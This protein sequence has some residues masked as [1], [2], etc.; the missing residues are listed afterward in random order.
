[1]DN[2]DETPSFGVIPLDYVKED[3]EKNE[4]VYKE[5]YVYP[6]IANG[7]RYLEWDSLAGYKVLCN[8]A[9]DLY[10]TWDIDNPERGRVSG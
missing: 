4:K 2:S 3:P 8:L 5:K 10:K 6:R 9:E 7:K 1:M